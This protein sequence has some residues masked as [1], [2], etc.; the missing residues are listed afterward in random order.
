MKNAKQYGKKIKKLLTGIDKSQTIIETDDD[1]I[2]VLVGAVLSSDATQAQAKKALELLDEEFVDYNELR[3][4]PPQDMIAIL[5]NDF[6][7][8]VGRGEQLSKALG[9]IFNRTCELSVEYMEKMSKRDLRKHLREIGLDQYSSAVMIQKVFTGHAIPVDQTLVDSLIM[10][11][12]VAPD[13]D[14]DDVQKFL[15]RLIQARNDAGAHKFFRQFVD[16]S[17]FALVKWRQKKL[18]EEQA[19]AAEA[20]AKAAKAAKTKAKAKAK[21]AAA[22]AKKQAKAKA[23]ARKTLTKTTKK[24]AVKKTVKKAAKKTVKK[25]AKKTAKKAA[26]KSATKTVTKATKK[27]AKKATK[28]TAKNTA[29]NGR[30]K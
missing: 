30:K 12:C 8:P 13:T 9:N 2:G 25:T 4:S 5:D 18:A 27:P 20:V 28:K 24:A 22:Q 23:A 15:E 17:A 26:K 29:K 6:S 16:K 3:G 7:N 10:N 19:A 14:I 21:K 1:P 11:D